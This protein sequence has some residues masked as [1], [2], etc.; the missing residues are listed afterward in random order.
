MENLKK[1]K[2]SEIVAKKGITK[3]ADRAQYEFGDSFLRDVLVTMIREGLGQEM[4]EGT[5]PPL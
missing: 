5:C 1:K 3:A 2:F 4:E